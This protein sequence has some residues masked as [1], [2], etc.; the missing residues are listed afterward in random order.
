MDCR[1]EWGHSRSGSA[2][3]RS[4]PARTIDELAGNDCLGYLLV[5]YESV[6]LHLGG[7]HSRYGTPTRNRDFHAQLVSGTDRLAKL[8]ALDA[9]ED[10]HFFAAILNFGEEESAT[11]LCDGLDDENSRHD[12][13]AGKVSHEKR[14]V[15]GDVLDGDYPLAALQ[16][17]DA[18][19]QQ[20]GIT[21]RQNFEN[22]VDVVRDLRR[23]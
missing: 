11:R 9:G 8:R 16:F 23:A 17:E 12:R 15:D 14:F 13:K 4:A 18:I 7:G 6:A 3:A 20:Q 19:N 2:V 22:V 5:A 21:V 1:A 10:H